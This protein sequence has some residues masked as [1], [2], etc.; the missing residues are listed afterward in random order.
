MYNNLL[1][2]YL[3]DCVFSVLCA[4]LSAVFLA[5]SSCVAFRL[6]TPDKKELTEDDRI[7]GGTLF[8]SEYF[9]QTVNLRFLSVY[10]SIFILFGAVCYL[11]AAAKIF[12]EN[13]FII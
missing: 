9:M 11:L 8:N 7:F 12:V 4:V 13:L 1:P 2:L 5:F 6:F 10:I 3:S